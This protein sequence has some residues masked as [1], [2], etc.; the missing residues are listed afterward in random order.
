MNMTGQDL[1]AALIRVVGI[2]LLAQMVSALYSFIV[3][4]FIAE[5][6]QPMQ[7]MV[8]SGIYLLIQLVLGLWL[9][10]CGSG[11]ARTLYKRV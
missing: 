11:I 4:A 10:F 1:C 7:A 8:L 3:Q 2:W 9:A 5:Q 6:G